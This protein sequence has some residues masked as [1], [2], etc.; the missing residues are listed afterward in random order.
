MISGGAGN[1]GALN[2][3]GQKVP[4]EVKPDTVLPAYCNPPNPCPVG[5]SAEDGCLE[6]FE[7]TAAFSRAYQG[8]QDCM[9][10]TEHMFDCHASQESDD[11]SAF[12]ADMQ[13]RILTSQ[14]KMKYLDEIDKHFFYL[15]E[16]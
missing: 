3:K 15:T 6:M 5:Y 11:E 13:V 8:S 2:V 7:N 1:T 10:D 9:C 4:T 16:Q 12:L 14:F